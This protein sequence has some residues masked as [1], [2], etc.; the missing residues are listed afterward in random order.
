M[1]KLL[2]FI[3]KASIYLTVF[4]VPLV[5]SPWTFESFEFPKQYVLIFL[6]LLGG[7]AWLIKMVLVD[8][9]IH[10]KRTPLD[11]PIFLFVLIAVLSSFFSADLWSSLFGNYGI[12]LAPSCTTNQDCFAH[13]NFHVQL[14][15]YT[16]Q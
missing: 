5:W 9:E 15:V 12:H 8:R 1:G 10:L 16:I 11:V 4:L 14:L 3:V 6:V 13:R 7:L 2:S